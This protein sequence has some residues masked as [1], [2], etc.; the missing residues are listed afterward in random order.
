MAFVFDAGP[1]VAFLNDEP[2]AEVVERLLNDNP[3]QCYAHGANL[4]EVFYPLL[5]L[6]GIE[7]AQ[8][9]IADLKAV[10]VQPCADM[11]EAFW[12][13]AAGYKAA[14]PMSLADA[15]CVALAARMNAELV[16]SDRHELEPLLDD[17]VV[18]ITFI[19]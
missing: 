16:T 4:C 5:R 1:L 19:R 6:D 9:A 17:G 10:G 18:K 11:D 14:Y 13:S 3:G 15:F 7:T 12:Q 8:Q 2:G